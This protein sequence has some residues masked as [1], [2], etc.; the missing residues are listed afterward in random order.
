MAVK[1]WD[2]GSG[3]LF[4]N[5]VGHTDHVYSLA[6]NKHCNVLASGET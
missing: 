1:V 2:L 3:S 4:K 6:F 5:F